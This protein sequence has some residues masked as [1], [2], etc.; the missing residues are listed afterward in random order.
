MLVK[1]SVPVLVVGWVEESVPGL[2]LEWVLASAEE[3][4]EV[5]V[6]AWEAQD[7]LSSR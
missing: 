4:V 5:L 3:S 7:S 6:W 2:E 1:E